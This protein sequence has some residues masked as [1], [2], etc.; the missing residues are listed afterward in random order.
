[1]STRVET[2]GT[3][4]GALASI[5]SW[6]E[7]A[8]RKQQAELLEVDQELQDLR[9]KVENLQSQIAAL[10]KF[11]LELESR[12]E[13]VEDQEVARGYSTLFAALHGQA[14]QVAQRAALAMEAEQARTDATIESIARSELA[15]RFEEYRQ[16]K[17]TVEPTLAALPDSYRSVIVQHHQQLAAKLRDHVARLL[18]G[19]VTLDAPELEIEL[20]Y[21]VDVPEGEPE[22]LIVVLPVADVVHAHWVERTEDLQT[23]L[24]ARVL[25]AIYLAVAEAGPPGA[26]AICGGHQGLLAIEADLLGAQPGIGAALT[27]HLEQVLSGA[28]ELAAARLRVVPREVPVDYLLPPEEDEEEPVTEARHA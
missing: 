21:G 5:A 7:E 14:L 9:S 10:E 25:Q 13:G 3:I 12:A 18:S 28:P 2:D 23:L 22:L 16:F 6:R 17:S 15:G 24:A 27:K 11:R 26:Q 8:R 19:P 1:M 20:V 4:K